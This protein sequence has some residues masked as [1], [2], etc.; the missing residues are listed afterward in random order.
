MLLDKGWFPC[1]E[2]YK[3][4]RVGFPALYYCSKGLQ[5]METPG[6]VGASKI[7]GDLPSLDHQSEDSWPTH[8]GAMQK[9]GMS[10]GVPNCGFLL[11]LLYSEN[12]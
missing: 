2:P 8:A 12:F 9:P 11:V 6:W 5:P 3:Y 10:E 1:R 4:K 7:T